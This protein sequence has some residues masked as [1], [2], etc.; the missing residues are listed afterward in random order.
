MFQNYFKIEIKKYAKTFEDKNIVENDK[1]PTD[2]IVLLPFDQNNSK[3]FVIVPYNRICVEL[4]KKVKNRAYSK[5][6]KC[7]IVDNTKEIINQVI[8]FFTTAGYKVYKQKNFA[9][10]PEFFVSQTNKSQKIEQSNLK[11][12][13]IEFKEFAKDPVKGLLFIVIIAIGYLYIDLKMNYTGQIKSQGIK[14]EK[15][16]VKV[17]QL[18][19]Q[20]RKSD[21]TLSAAASKIQVLQELGKIK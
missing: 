19:E 1:T 11:I 6:N 8:L 18:T 14:V 7:W 2:G 10:E 21:S 17:E 20:L 16:E 4:I 5:A 3:L 13:T 15:L 12:F 9:T